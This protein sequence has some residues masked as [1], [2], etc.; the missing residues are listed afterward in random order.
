MNFTHPRLPPKRGR[1]RTQD[2]GLGEL[3]A[4][5]EAVKMAPLGRPL[6]VHT[7]NAGT[8]T[9]VRRGTKRNAQLDA[10]AERV[11]AT[12]EAR[13]ITLTV[14]HVSREH[15]N[16]RPAHEGA[17]A[18][19]KGVRD[20]RVGPRVEVAIQVNPR[21]REAYIR[22]KRDGDLRTLTEPL[23]INAP[24]DAPLAA[25]LVAVEHLDVG[26]WAFVRID[27]ALVPA[28]VG[29]KIRPVNRS[30]REYVQLIRDAAARKGVKLRFE[31]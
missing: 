23:D 1:I 9:I 28:Y 16:I 26:E 24:V 6:T 22:L 10:L 18:A 13:G 20:K 19:R 4:V 21:R 29:G 30:V 2:N 27:S 11:R 15:R 3:H 25:L 7:D 31:E 14:V 8:P 17:N 5:F 12:A